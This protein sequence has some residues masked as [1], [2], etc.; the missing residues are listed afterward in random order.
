MKTSLLKKVVETGGLNW[1]QLETA[2]TL[3]INTH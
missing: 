1:E 3:P 2:L